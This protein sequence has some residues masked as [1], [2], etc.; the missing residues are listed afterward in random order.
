MHLYRINLVSNKPEHIG[1]VPPKLSE[2]S[3]PSPDTVTYHVEKKDGWWI[4]TRVVFD[5]HR[6]RRRKAVGRYATEQEAERAGAALLN[7]PVEREED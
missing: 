6:K 5:K 4:L 3:R 1:Y 2:V 7:L